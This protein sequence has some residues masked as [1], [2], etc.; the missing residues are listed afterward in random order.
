M[1]KFLMTLLLCSPVLAFASE[2]CSTTSGEETAQEQ[3]EIKTDVPSHLKGA[4]II[5]RLADGRETTVP[6]EQFKVVARK[7]QFIVT[8]TKQLD[9][10]VCS[11]ELNKNRVSLL[12]GNGPKEGLTR[13]TDGNTVTV[14]S[15]TG[16][17]GGLQYQRLITDHISV[18][19]Q[20]QS[21]ESALV[22][23]GLDF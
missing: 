1:K 7:Q 20:L 18:G 6:A 21:N 9:K 17:V 3:L 12:G 19:A 2:N 15:K 14:E 23:V 8:K 22:E 11:A 5:V 4:T 16:V 13:T 10:T